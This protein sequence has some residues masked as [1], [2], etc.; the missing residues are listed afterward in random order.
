MGHMTSLM[1]YTTCIVTVGV[2][3][4]I[5]LLYTI[6]CCYN[7]DLFYIV[8]NNLIWFDFWA[9]LQMSRVDNIMCN[10]IYLASMYQCDTKMY[11]HFFQHYRCKII[12]VSQVNLYIN[13][14]V[15]GGPLLYQHW[16]S[17]T[18]TDGILQPKKT[19]DNDPV[20][21]WRWSSVVDDG[22]TSY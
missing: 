22:P 15:N 14:R 2:F 21:V 8:C 5:V 7:C 12:A 1:L 4:H 19:R 3:I 13:R 6:C 11:L 20:L 10:K 16:A 17:G 9:Q 18:I